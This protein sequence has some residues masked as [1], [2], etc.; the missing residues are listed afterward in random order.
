MN[1]KIL[2]TASAGVLGLAGLVAVF[3][4]EFPLG[5]LGV[6]PANFPAVVVQLLGTLYLSFASMNWLARGSAIGGIY[7]RPISMANFTHFFIGALVL[8]KVLLAGG[9]SV[10]VVVSA[11]IYAVFALLFWWLAFKHTGLVEGAS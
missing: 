2:M 9:S 10:L 8:V 5:A 11:G 1:T 7:A 6:A 3:A 4:P